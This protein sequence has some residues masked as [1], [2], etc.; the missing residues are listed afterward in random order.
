MDL[1]HCMIQITLQHST[2]IMME[3]N[4]TRWMRLLIAACF[5]LWLEIEVLEVRHGFINERMRVNGVGD[6]KLLYPRYRYTQTN[7]PA[8]PQHKSSFIQWRNELYLDRCDFNR[9]LD[10]LWCTIMNF[11]NKTILPNNRHIAPS[12]IKTSSTNSPPRNAP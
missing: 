7:Q 12:P 8:I 3:S 5:D 4:H 1:R 11:T 10:K 9:N 6:K 2:D